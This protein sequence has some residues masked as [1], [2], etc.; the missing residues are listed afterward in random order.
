[1]NHPGTLKK[2]NASGYYKESAHW[3]YAENYEM[4]RFGFHGSGR[5]LW[6]I[7]CWSGGCPDEEHPLNESWW[8]TRK[9]AIAA[10]DEYLASL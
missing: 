8:H 6:I 9:E 5:K 1:M 2:L 4:L 10:I 3:Q 7:C